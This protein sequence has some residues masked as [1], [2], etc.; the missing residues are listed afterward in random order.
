MIQGADLL[1]ESWLTARQHALFDFLLPVFNALNMHRVYTRDQLLLGNHQGPGDSTHPGFLSPADPDRSLL[2]LI[3]RHTAAAPTEFA[4]ARGTAGPTC[5]QTIVVGIGYLHTP[6]A[7]LEAMARTA[8]LITPCGGTGA[9]SIFLPPGATA[10]VMNYYN[11]AAGVS[12][13][14]EE[15]FYSNVEHVKYQY[16][17]ILTEDYLDT[18]N[19]PGCEKSE[20]DVNSTKQGKFIDCNVR[21]RDAGRLQNVVAAAQLR[22]QALAVKAE[23]LAFGG[24]HAE[25]LEARNLVLEKWQS[26]VSRYLSADECA[27]AAGAAGGDAVRGAHLFLEEQGSINVG[28]LQSDPLVEPAAAPAVTRER[29]AAETLKILKSVDIAETTERMIRKQLES[30]LAYI[31]G[32]TLPVAE[33]AAKARP[34]KV[35]GRVIIVGAGPAGLAAATHLKRCGVASVVLE[36]R[37]RVG[38]RVHTYRGGGFSVPIDLGASIITGTAVDLAKGARADP[39]A[40]VARQL[41]VELHDLRRELAIFDGESGE[42]VPPATDARIEALVNH[43][44]DTAREGVDEA[45]DDP[46]RPDS[47]LG[48]ALDSALA[49]HLSAAG[50]PIGVSLRALGEATTAAAEAVAQEHERRKEAGDAGAAPAAAAEL[51]HSLSEAERRLLDWHWANLEYGC[52]ARLDQVSLAHWN[53]D[54]EYG[55]FGGPHAMVRG[56]YSGLMEPLAARLDVRLGAPVATIADSEDGVRVTTTS[57]EVF[58][59]A[60]VIV[61]VP[62]GCLKAGTISF[63]P[64]LP[65]WKSSAIAKLGFGNLNKVIMEFQ[66]AFWDADA[67]YFG[68]ALPG[69]AEGRGRCFMFWNLQRFTGAPVLAALAAGAAAGEAEAASDAEL[70]AA[71][72]G[73]LRRIYGQDVVP[74]PRAVLA[75]RWASEEFTRGSYSYV[76][77][78]ASGRTYD[79]LSA[80]VRRR[81]LFAGEHTCKEHPDTVGGAMLTGMREA[82]RALSLLRGD[83]GRFGA[84]AADDVATGP[85]VKRRAAQAEKDRRPRKRRAEDDDSGDERNVRVYRDPAV[86]AAEEA[87]REAARDGHRQLWAALMAGDTMGLEGL[88]L[89]ST[90]A[91]ARAALAAELVKA[92]ADMLRVLAGHLGCMR[93]LN[94]WLLDLASDARDCHALELVLQVLR[95][96]PVQWGALKQSGVAVTVRQRAAEHATRSVRAAAAAVTQRWADATGDASLATAPP[97]AAPAAPAAQAVAA[98]VRRDASTPSPSEEAAEVLDEGVR[99]R[100]A[101]AEAAAQEAATLKMEAALVEAAVAE[102]E[103]TT[104]AAREAAALPDIPDFSAYAGE[105]RRQRPS[106]SGREA[107]LARRKSWADKALAEAGDD[108]SAAA[109]GA[110]PSAP[111][112]TNGRLPAPRE[113]EAASAAGKSSKVKAEVAEYVKKLLKPLYATKRIS[114]EHF[115]LVAEKSAQKVAEQ[116]VDAGSGPFLSDKRQAKVRALVD[117]YLKRYS[118]AGSEKA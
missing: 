110:P 2:N 82:V 14:L 15:K 81:L 64:P 69:G 63:Q 54:D 46:A 50:M 61:T 89:S 60:A 57:G 114:K 6:H 67:D 56:G 105:Q 33:A 52:S 10:I 53:Q 106:R 100:L 1:I 19:R 42:P 86:V 107:K 93:A 79:Q 62:L 37:T 36:A 73:V 117:K 118:G 38:G 16:F 109:A 13:Q 34:A 94:I 20:Q 83:D 98:L 3:S 96:M 108:A 95:T 77:V 55:G 21:I 18:T 24:R 84:A 101:E 30:V 111:A 97:Q 40:I 116:A 113:A 51:P 8:I 76:A 104:E 29:I 22:W 12:M 74:E 78:G 99:Q 90:D 44:L 80:P 32:T 71:A 43:L 41:G 115:K 102:A 28:L 4:A 47:S 103:A 112:P 49:A 92:R 17:P 87:Q 85:L 75:T 70:G 23:R 39:S 72:V 65:D 9:I 48:A 91:A 5:F 66:E 35:K 58:T 31:Q 11:D 59:G 45:D 88:L 7:R 26:N 27:A 68:A 25:Y